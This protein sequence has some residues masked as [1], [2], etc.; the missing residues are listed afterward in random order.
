M[1]SITDFQYMS[2]TFEKQKGTENPYPLLFCLAYSHG[3]EITLSILD[4]KPLNKI[5][6]YYAKR[7]KVLMAEIGDFSDAKHQ[8]A[9]ATQQVLIYRGRSVL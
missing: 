4:W 6:N 2:N 5:L 3:C 1:K 7:N 8:V 9:L